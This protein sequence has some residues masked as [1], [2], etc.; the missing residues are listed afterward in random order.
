MLQ[1]ALDRASTALRRVKA[2]EFETAPGGAHSRI[3]TFLTTPIW[4]RAG[5]VR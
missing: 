2:C 4:R 5:N 3:G 1:S